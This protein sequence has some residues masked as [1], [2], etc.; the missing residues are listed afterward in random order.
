MHQSW[1]ASCL[2]LTVAC[3]SVD[4]APLSVDAS[5]D[6]SVATHSTD[7]PIRLPDTPP[8]RLV[9][10]W[11]DAHNAGDE[12]ALAAWIEASYAPALLERVD[13]GE[14]VAFYQNIVVD[15]GK[16]S[17]VPLAILESS[18]QR[19]VVHLR[20]IEVFHPDPLTTL[21][22][23]LEVAPEDPAHVARA[24]GLGALACENKKP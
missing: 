24:L 23:E 17:P 6:E 4:P 8:G 14:H 7:A 9:H 12:V 13:V 3:S 5:H 18:A 15:F 1:I 11:I 2:A 22:V 19:L 21:V 16:L 20:P 10:A